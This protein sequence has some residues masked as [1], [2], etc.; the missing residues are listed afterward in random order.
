MRAAH[1][2]NSSVR[3]YF[4]VVPKMWLHNV[5]IFAVLWTFVQS[6]VIKNTI[7]TE[8]TQ[9]PFKHTLQLR[10]A[11]GTE[12]SYNNL[13]GGVES[14]IQFRTNP[15]KH[16]KCLKWIKIKNNRFPWRCAKFGYE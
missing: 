10:V 5:L 8:P 12:S 16:K 7:Q 2:Q 11:V 15:I 13:A 1:S 9:E 14:K 4:K 6:G 3:N